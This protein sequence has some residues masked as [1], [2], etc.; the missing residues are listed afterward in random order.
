[1]PAASRW[2]YSKKKRKSGGGSTRRPNFPLSY[3]PRFGLAEA[4]IIIPESTPQKFLQS[5]I[6]LRSFA[7]VS[8]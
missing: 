8:A 6:N 5:T 2:W 7:R 1:M 3:I 4:M